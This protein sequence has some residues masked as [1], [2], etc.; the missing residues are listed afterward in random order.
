MD[1]KKGK[2]FSEI[3]EN[4]KYKVRQVTQIAQLEENLPGLPK[5]RNIVR[6]TFEDDS[7]EGDVKRF[8]LNGGGYVITSYW[9]N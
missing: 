6:W 2:D 5:Q 7:K 1:S 9:K 4:E 8:A 3:A